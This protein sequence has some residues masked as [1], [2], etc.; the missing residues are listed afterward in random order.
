MFPTGAWVFKHFVTVNIFTVILITLTI[1][2][3]MCLPLKPPALYV[4]IIKKP[5][6]AGNLTTQQTFDF[7]VDSHEYF[8]KSFPFRHSVQLKSFG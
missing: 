5:A 6:E 2:E 7:R 4:H 8:Q 3:V 1:I